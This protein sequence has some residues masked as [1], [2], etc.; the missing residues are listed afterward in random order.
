[1]SRVLLTG[2]ITATQMPRPLI[3]QVFLLKIK[4]QSTP[5][6]PVGYALGA[7]KISEKDA[8]LHQDLN[9]VSNVVGIEEMQ[10]EEVT[11]FTI[12]HKDTLLLS[13]D[14]LS[15]NLYSNEI[16]ALACKLEVDKAILELASSTLKR[17]L[18]PKHGRPSK[19][20]DTT[21]VVFRTKKET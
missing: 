13:S 14:G 21:I 6:S 8:L 11:P 18:N 5:H 16:A 4:Y 7:G 10:I 3:G 12:A 1:M 20:D 19:P 15:D 17:M 9:L 2:T